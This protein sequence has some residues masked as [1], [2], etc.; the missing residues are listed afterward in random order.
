MGTVC[1][2]NPLVFSGIDGADGGSEDCEPGG[3]AGHAVL[4]ASCSGESNG[5]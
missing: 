2:A 4:V 3:Q 5:K 1:D